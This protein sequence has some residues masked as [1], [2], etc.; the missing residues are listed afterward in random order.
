MSVS[1]APQ[2]ALPVGTEV[3]LFNNRRSSCGV[4]S[5]ASSASEIKDIIGPL[6]RL[7]LTFIA[8]DP[9]NDAELEALPL[10]TFNCI[11]ILCDQSWMVKGASPDLKTILINHRAKPGPNN[12][13]GCFG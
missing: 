12:Q 4:H 6:S 11:I 3:V 7:N 9:L 5:A 8:G 13:L 2:A 10:S 1:C